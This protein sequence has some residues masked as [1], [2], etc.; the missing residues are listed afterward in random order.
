MKKEAESESKGTS[1]SSNETN[2]TTSDTQGEKDIIVIV[3]QKNV[4]SL[5]SSERFEELT[6]EVEG[7]RWD[8]P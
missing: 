5:D 1:G 6:H 4:R 2:K 7:C 8:A 3:L